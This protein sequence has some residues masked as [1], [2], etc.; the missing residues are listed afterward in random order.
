MNKEF[1]VGLMAGFFTVFIIFTIFVMFYSVRAGC[2]SNLEHV[3]NSACQMLAGMSCSQTAS[4]I[5]V[6]GF[7]ANKDGKID[8]GD[9]L[10]EL[11]KN[12]YDISDDLD[13]KTRICGC[14]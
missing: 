1:I 2:G 10:F 12:Y 9:T 5:P 6:R 8:S 4:S 13:C 11:C 14:P 3:K 7:D